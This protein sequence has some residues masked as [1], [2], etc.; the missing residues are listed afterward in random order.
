M[1]AEAERPC[2]NG[3]GCCISLPHFRTVAGHQYPHLV[4]G[5]YR[6]WCGQEERTTIR[7]MENLT[8]QFFAKL[9]AWC[10]I[11][12][13][14]AA[15]KKAQSAINSTR[16]IRRARVEKSLLSGPSGSVRKHLGK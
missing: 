10:F 4:V 2:R 1:A 11:P 12:A 7:G 8:F 13:F 5:A 9:F 14:L 15:R 16:Y 3:A 6:A